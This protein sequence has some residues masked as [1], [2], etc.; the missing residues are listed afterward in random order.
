MK[1]KNRILSVILAFTMCCACAIPACALTKIDVVKAYFD[2]PKAGDHF[3]FGAVKTAEPEKYTATIIDWFYYDYSAKQYV[4]PTASDTLQK[5][6]GYSCRIRFAGIGEYYLD[7]N[8]GTKYFVNGNRVTDFGGTF[9]PEIKYRNGVAISGIDP[10]S[11]ESMSIEI[12]NYAAERTEDYRATIT[13]TAKTDTLLG[14][15]AIHFFINDVDQGANDT[16]TVKEAK[17]D[18]TVQA[19]L[20]SSGGETL[21]ESLVETVTIRHGFFDKLKAFFRGLFRKLPV[22][23]QAYLGAE[24]VGAL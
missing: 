12:V 24:I 13:F 17:A 11:T 22:I 7:Y 16:C 4:H 6:F 18:Y 19:K 14:D 5:D 21:C 3:L 20:M 10:S 1:T 2:V 23:T 15:A 9:M 8:P